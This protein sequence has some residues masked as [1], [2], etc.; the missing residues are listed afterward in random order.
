MIVDKK[1]DLNIYKER[2]E[3]ADCCGP[4]K[5]KSEENAAESSCRGPS[6]SC[7]STSNEWKQ[8]KVSKKEMADRVKDIDFNEWVSKY[9]HCTLFYVR[10]E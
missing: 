5:E 3:E 1:G 10:T 7:C 8:S 4:S 2:G 6:D 9:I